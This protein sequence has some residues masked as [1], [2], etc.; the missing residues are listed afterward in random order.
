MDSRPYRQG[1]YTSYLL[2]DKGEDIGDAVGTEDMVDEEEI[3]ENENMVDSW[4]I[5]NEEDIVDTMVDS[6]SMIDD[7]MTSL[8]NENNEKSEP[9]YYYYYYYDES[10][11]DIS[12]ELE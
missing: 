9:S 2:A 6:W 1:P 7:S 11:I 12:N 4:E 5:T 3:L 10:G 8:G